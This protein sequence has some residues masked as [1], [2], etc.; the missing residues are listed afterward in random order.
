MSNSLKFTDE[1]GCITID[2]KVLDH[3]PLEDSELSQELK[4][5]ISLKFSANNAQ[6]LDDHI[7]ES[8]QKNGIK[9]R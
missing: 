4:S 9:K 3:Q 2:V 1:S 5:Q 7:M 6:S 8:F